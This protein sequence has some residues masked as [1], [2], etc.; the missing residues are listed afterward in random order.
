MVD[1]PKIPTRLLYTGDKV[2]GRSY[3]GLGKKRHS[4][5]VTALSYAAPPNNK[6]GCNTLK[7]ENGVF[8]KTTISHGL[9]TIEIY[10]PIDEGKKRKDKGGCFCNAC[11]TIGLIISIDN[12]T[13]GVESRPA[14][15][16]LYESCTDNFHGTSAETYTV[17]VCKNRTS[18]VTVTGCVVIDHATYCPGDR[19]ALM[20]YPSS[21]EAFV[22]L[23][24]CHS[25]CNSANCGVVEPVGFTYMICPLE[26]NISF[27]N[28]A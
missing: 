13:E 12:C 10:V 5:L 23:D 28:S 27:F 2:K 1:F 16:K 25:G 3:A 21:D 26:V 15:D 8:I 7:L 17:A 18:A 6:T 11:F 24:N 19:V 22:K 20:R 9:S 4:D 14:C